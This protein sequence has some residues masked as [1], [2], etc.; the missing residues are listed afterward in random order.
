LSIA[1]PVRHFKGLAPRNGWC[2]PTSTAFRVFSVLTSERLGLSRQRSSFARPGAGAPWAPHAVTVS[3]THRTLC[4]R[5]RLK[6][7]IAGRVLPPKAK[8]AAVGHLRWRTTASAA[9]SIVGIGQVGAN[10]P[11]PLH[12][13][14][15][16]IAAIAGGGS[17]W[18]YRPFSVGPGP[19][20]LTFTAHCRLELDRRRPPQPRGSSLRRRL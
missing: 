8:D 4:F 1:L 20:K 11:R 19:Q 14:L 5:L 12:D 13:R 15:R 2:K 9:D 10:R 18:R 17:N 7:Y 6:Y 3:E 16:R